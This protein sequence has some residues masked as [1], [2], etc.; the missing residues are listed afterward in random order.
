MVAA[1]AL[2][3]GNYSYASDL[4]LDIMNSQA[5][6]AISAELSA[7]NIINWKV[8]DHAEYKITAM[9]MEIGKLATRADRDEGN[10]VWF[11]QEMTGMQQQK[12]EMLIDRLNGKTVKYLVNGQQQTPP[13][14]KI[15]IVSQDA[16]SV[17][18][19][20]G[21]FESIHIVATTSNQQIKQIEIWANPRDIVLSG[22][23]QTKMDTT[24]GISILMQMTGFGH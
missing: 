9:N 11:V 1:A 4:M 6:S 21:T 7:K 14:D 16:Q 13:D 18:V 22:M 15:E 23:I 12:V 10:N 19:P 2:M 20:A 17:T 3:V 8:G 24:Q 5:Q